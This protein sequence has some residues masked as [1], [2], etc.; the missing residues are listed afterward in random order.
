MAE[1]GLTQQERELGIMLFNFYDRMSDLEEI[2]NDQEREG[3]K[4]TLLIMTVNDFNEYIDK[5]TTVHDNNTN[6]LTT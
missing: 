4:A 2:E 6:T 1:H 5:K 3:K